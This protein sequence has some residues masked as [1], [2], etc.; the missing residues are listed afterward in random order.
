MYLLSAPPVSFTEGFPHFTTIF[1]T[2]QGPEITVF[3]SGV[4]VRVERAN[5]RRA[6]KKERHFAGFWEGT[7]CHLYIASVT[8]GQFSLVEFNQTCP[9][10]CVTWDWLQPIIGRANGWMKVNKY[11]GKTKIHPRGAFL[12]WC[13]LPLLIK[14]KSE[15]VCE[16]NHWAAVHSAENVY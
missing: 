13:P 3:S 1:V 12:A 4:F 6:G 2:I 9:G 15:T 7:W 14:R 8:L 11:Y 16:V 10:S 5:D